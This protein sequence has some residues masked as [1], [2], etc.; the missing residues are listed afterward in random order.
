MVSST[1]PSHSPPYLPRH[2][3]L[4]LNLHF[5]TFVL[6]FPR[7]IHDCMPSFLPV[8]H[9]MSDNSL[10]FSGLPALTSLL[11]SKR[12]PLQTAW[13]PL[14]ISSTFC[15]L[16][17]QHCFFSTYSACTTNISAFSWNEGTI[18]LGEGE[19]VATIIPTKWCICVYYMIVYIYIYI[20]I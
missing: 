11:L 14:K 10:T 15:P 5:S 19:N 18:L 9:N 16:H 17:L 1:S 2:L 6:Y 3:D 8:L 12:Q 20:I 4:C 7:N 13:S